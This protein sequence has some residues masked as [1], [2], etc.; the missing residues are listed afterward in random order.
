[1]APAVTAPGAPV[2][3]Q[4]IQ[5]IFE[6]LCLLHTR[7]DAGNCRFCSALRTFLADTRAAGYFAVWVVSVERLCMLSWG[8]LRVQI[9]GLRGSD[10][11]MSDPEL[12]VFLVLFNR[13]KPHSGS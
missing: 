2:P 13:A 5:S 7:C 11:P 6:M 9:A 1:M 3:I 12:F 8:G 4:G 10:G